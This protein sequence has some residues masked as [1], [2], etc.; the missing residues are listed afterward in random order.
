MNILSPS[1]LAIDFGNMERDLVEAWEAGANTIHLD[2]MD[3]MFVPSISFGMPVIKYV[4]KAL[5]DAFLDA[6]MMVQNPSRYFDDIIEAGADSITIHY[7]ATDS[8][9]KDIELLKEKGVKVGV[10]I[11]PDTPVSCIEDIIESVDMILVMTVYPGFGG[12]KFIDDSL[13]RIKAVKKMVDDKNLNVNI[14]VD[15]GITLQNVQTVINAGANVIV[16]GSAV[17]T[18]DITG[19]IKSFLKLLKECD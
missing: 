16:S 1:V 9:K 6:H 8:V 11:S 15:G 19:S 5:P 13:D 3:G 12:Q 7:E 10:A 4:R 18:D 14:E 2:V 17:F